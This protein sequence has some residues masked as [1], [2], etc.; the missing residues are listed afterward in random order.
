MGK[1]RVG[2]SK[3]NNHS[4]RRKQDTEVKRFLEFAR[5]IGINPTFDEYLQTLKRLLPRRRRNKRRRA[6][7]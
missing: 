4:K 7:V 5:S 1:S 2:E 3:D 6:A